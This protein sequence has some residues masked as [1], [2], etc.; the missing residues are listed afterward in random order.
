[1]TSPRDDPQPADL[2]ASIG[3]WQAWRDR[4]RAAEASSRVTLVEG[5]DPRG[6]VTVRIDQRWRVVAVRVANTWRD[7]VDPVDLG[8]AVVEAVADAV[9]ERLRPA[10][11]MLV[12]VD[13]LRGTEIWAAVA[14]EDADLGGELARLR[15]LRPVGASHLSIDVVEAELAE[16]DRQLSLQEA[17]AAPPTTVVG[18][19]RRHEVEVELGLVGLPVRVGCRLDWLR[20]TSVDRLTSALA[21]AFVDA[22]A[23]A[24]ADLTSASIPLDGVA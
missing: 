9:Q 15:G 19:S 5:R 24:D 6:A 14:A 1:M 3:R 23:T 11:D 17:Q 16:V 18:R 13:A 10:V 20:T 12:D 22:Y 7:V 8:A 21:G 4:A 2:Q